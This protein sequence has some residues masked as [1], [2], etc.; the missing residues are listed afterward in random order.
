MNLEGLSLTIISF[1]VFVIG[2][3]MIIIAGKKKTVC[4]TLWKNERVR[5]PS[6]IKTTGSQEPDFQHPSYLF[7]LQHPSLIKGAIT[8][9]MGPFKFYICEYFDF[10]IT[11]IALSKPKIYYEAKSE[12]LKPFELEMPPGNYW[13]FFFCKSANTRAELTLTECHHIKP[14]KKWFNIGQTLWEVGIPVLI[15]GL[16][17]LIPIP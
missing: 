6:Y 2:A 8:E 7:S 4:T 9:T 1:A 5:P 10:H 3:I 16:V 17:S 11:P 15:V 12:D 13:A 14:Y